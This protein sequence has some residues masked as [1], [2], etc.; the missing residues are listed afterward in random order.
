MKKKAKH[1][2]LNFPTGTK[3]LKWERYLNVLWK[4]KWGMAEYWYSLQS[5]LLIFFSFFSLQ[6]S[7]WHGLFS[8]YDLSFIKVSASCEDHL[9]HIITLS[10]LTVFPDS[11]DLFLGEIRHLLTWSVWNMLLTTNCLFMGNKCSWINSKHWSISIGPSELYSQDPRKQ[12]RDYQIEIT[13]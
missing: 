4:N 2:A 3:W 7:T 1:T 6:N 11:N 8:D 5:L 9:L 13:R 12:S 10:T